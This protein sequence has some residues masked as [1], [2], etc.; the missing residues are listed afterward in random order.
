MRSF[1]LAAVTT[2]AGVALSTTA[3]AQTETVLW[4]FPYNSSPYARLAR[5]STTGSLY[6]TTVHGGVG[7][8]TVFSLSDKHEVW[9]HHLLYKFGGGSDGADSYGGLSED[10]TGDLYGTTVYGGNTD[11]GTAFELT[12][13]GTSWTH[14]VLHSFGGGADGAHPDADLTIDKATGALYGTT[15]DGGSWGCGTVFELS[16]S[17]TE[18]VLYAFKGGNDGCLPQTPVRA[19]STKGSLYGVTGAGGAQNYGVVYR[20]K[21]SLGVWSESVI[22]TFAGGADGENPTDFDVDPKTGDLYGAAGGGSSGNGIVFELTPA[23]K[24]WQE[25]VL[26]TFGGAPDGVGPVGLHLDAATGVLSGT[27][28]YGGTS[29]EGTVFQLTKN[30]N[31]WV[32]AQLHSFGASGDGAYPEARPAEDTTTG[33][34]YGTTTKGGAYNVG[35]AYLIVP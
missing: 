31:T 17:G 11:V 13:N 29:G 19:G 24:D 15:F 35:T 2:A 26:Y 5:D 23:K 32:E 12:F 25:R 3:I 30:G 8:G 6:G 27:T 33:Y 16:P 10:A 18:T 1:F 34:L 20:L 22:H 4:S 9:K 21:E 28:Y 14:T 7:Y